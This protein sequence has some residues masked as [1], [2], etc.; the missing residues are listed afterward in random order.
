MKK[1]LFLLI[2][3][4][5]ACTYTY[6]VYHY[7]GTS[8]AYEGDIIENETDAGTTEMKFTDNTVVIF[9]DGIPVARSGYEFNSF[10]RY[11]NLEGIGT[12]ERIS[13]SK[14]KLKHNNKDYI[15][16]LNI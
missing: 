14:L 12:V 1:I 7:E 15:F 10:K 3:A 16:S 9:E 2:F 4:L 11:I 6:E 8:W 5:V 13:F